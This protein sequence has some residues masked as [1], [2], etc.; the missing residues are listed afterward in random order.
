MGEIKKLDPI[1]VSS[2]IFLEDES[3]EKT[4]ESI[5][6]KVCRFVFSII[7]DSLV[8]ALAAIAIVQAVLVLHQKVRLCSSD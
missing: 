6:A 3:A 5:L 8:G 1:V 2:C 4:V 7:E